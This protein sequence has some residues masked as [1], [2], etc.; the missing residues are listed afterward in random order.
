MIVTQAQSKV[1]GGLVRALQRLRRVHPDMTVLQALVLFHV[2]DHPGIGQRRLYEELGINDSAASRI[3]AVLSDWGTRS[4]GGLGL[5]VIET[6]PED[7]REHLLA[8][9]PDGR[10]LIE[11]VTGDLRNAKLRA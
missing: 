3:L 1:A 5:I 10:K 8:L 11:Q 6:N 2:A 7:R 4:T 9:S